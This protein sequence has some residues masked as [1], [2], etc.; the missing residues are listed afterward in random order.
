MRVAQWGAEGDVV[1][2]TTT[3]GG[4][5]WLLDQ[6]RASRERVMEHA[7]Y[8]EMHTRE[9]LAHFMTRHVYAVWDFMSLL[10][11]LQRRVTCVDVPWLPVGSPAARRLVN[12]IVLDEESDLVDG[13]IVSHFELYL[14]AMQEVGA[15][16]APAT[17]F[18]EGLRGGASV[19]AAMDL[20][21][22]PEAARAFVRQTLAFAQHGSVY[23][24]AAA[25]T[26]GREDAIPDMFRR[27]LAAIPNAPRM[28]QY[29]E[30]HIALDGDEHA[31]QGFALLEALC[32]ESEVRWREAAHASQRALDARAALWTG[33]A[34]DFRRR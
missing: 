24:V 13:V 29:L 11:A 26:L 3:V 21:P 9:H 19:E 33:I 1:T 32:G 6:V 8:S 28:A 27:L 18:V 12:A 4:R 14:T 23:E 22:M 7:L 34:E 10:K 16:T 20:A 2:T 30:R 25:F 17:R 5:G 15:D 31:D